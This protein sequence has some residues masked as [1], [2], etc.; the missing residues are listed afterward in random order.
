MCAAGGVTVA[1]SR[2]S[3]RYWATVPRFDDGDALWDVIFAQ[4]LEG[5][6]AKRLTDYVPGDRWRWVKTK[7]PSW[8]RRVL[9]VLE[10][11]GIGKAR[12]RRRKTAVEGS[13]RV[14]AVS[15]GG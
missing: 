14:N 2:S 10:R 3:D 13:S 7:S 1:A 11:E 9:R 8:P 5:V 12:D 6:V 4:Q 15:T